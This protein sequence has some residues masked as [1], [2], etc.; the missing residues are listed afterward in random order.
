MKLLPGFQGEPMSVHAKIIT[1]GLF[2]MLALSACGA[3]PTA[4]ADTIPEDFILVEQTNV[5][6]NT[7]IT[8]E[9]VTLKGMTGPATVS[10]TGGEYA[11]DAGAFATTDGSIKDGQSIKLRVTSSTDFST[12]ASAVIKIGGVPA[13]FKVTTVAPNVT[14]TAFAFTDQTDVP[15]NSVRTSNA[16]TVAGVEAGVAISV[17]NGEYAVDGGAFTNAAGTVSN[18]QSVVVRVTSSAGFNT[19]TNAILTIGG[20]SDTF[21]VTTEAEDTTPNAFTFTDLTDVALNTAMTSASISVAGIN[22]S[23]AI[24]VTGAEY[25]VN[26]GAFTGVAGTVTNGQQVRLRLTSSTTLITAKNATVTIGGVSD[27]WTVSTTDT[28]V[29]VPQLWGYHLYGSNRNSSNPSILCESTYIDRGAVHNPTLIN[30]P[31]NVSSTTGMVISSLKVYVF[32]SRHLGS[33]LRVRLKS[34]T[35]ETKVLLVQPTPSCLSEE[36]PTVNNYGYMQLTFDDGAS[37]VATDACITG[38]C[39]GSAKPNEALSAFNGVDPS[40]NWTVQFDD[41]SSRDYVG[42]IFTASL[43]ITYKAAP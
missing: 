12:A 24:S 1:V 32:M 6:R 42:Y 40:G 2:A 23:A 35:G 7:A 9:A 30:V 20:V 19:A 31:I 15:R 14:P 13:T 25:S 3:A 43:K 16:I 4:T 18:G 29:H 17:T 33:D 28:L 27:T 21:A 11:I 22:S 34:P 36:P 38:A 8:S 39:S 10:I 41:R 26:G 5:A 37:N